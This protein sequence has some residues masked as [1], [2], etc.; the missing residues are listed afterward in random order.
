MVEESCALRGCCHLAAVFS[1][2][3]KYIASSLQ[4]EIPNLGKDALFCEADKNQCWRIAE[5]LQSYWQMLFGRVNE[6]REVQQGEVT[7]SGFKE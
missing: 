6:R 5:I 7:E 4:I 1:T 3:C 2:N